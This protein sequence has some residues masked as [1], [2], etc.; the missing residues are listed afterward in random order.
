MIDLDLSSLFLYS[1]ALYFSPDSIYSF[2]SVI[3]AYVP[4]QFLSSYCGIP[5][6][7]LMNDALGSER[8]DPR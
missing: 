6:S 4:H 2:V 7:N 5:I 8:A 1:F 3:D